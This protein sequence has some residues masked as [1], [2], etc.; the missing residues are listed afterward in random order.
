MPVWQL[1]SEPGSRRGLRSGG[2]MSH[3][4]DDMSFEA[5]EAERVFDFVNLSFGAFLSAYI[6]IKLSQSEPSS[7]EAI[8]IAA[9]L[10][11]V[12]FV[13]L[14]LRGLGLPLILGTATLKHSLSA[15]VT[16]IAGGFAYLTV[17]REL[18]YSLEVM[19][20]IGLGWLIAPAILMIPLILRRWIKI[21][22]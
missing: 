1:K 10:I 14:S 22:D 18:G 5:H 8:K 15:L 20:P 16:L 12:A 11:V 9:L 4:D 17:C 7:A 6:G 13:G 2:E 3:M 21:Y 19:G